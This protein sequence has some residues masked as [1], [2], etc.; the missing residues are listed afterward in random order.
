M[1][2][3]PLKLKLMHSYV[4]VKQGIFNLNVYSYLNWYNIVIFLVKGYPYFSNTVLSTGYIPGYT[5][6]TSVTEC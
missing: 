6:Y 5:E 3:S 4:C 1:Y 2:N